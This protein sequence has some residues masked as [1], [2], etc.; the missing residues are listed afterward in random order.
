MTVI[1][2]NNNKRINICLKNEG[3]RLFLA[4]LLGEWGFMTTTTCPETEEDLL[5]ADGICSHCAGHVNRINLLSSPYIDSDHVNLPIVIEKLWQSVEKHYHRPPRHHLRLVVDYP[6]EMELR[7]SVQPGQL[8][9]LS[10]AGA[11][12]TLPRELAVGEI[13]PI[14]LLLPRQQQPLQL[15]GRVI[16]V[17]TFP[18]HQN[19]YDAGVLFE[20][21]ESQEKTLLRNSIVFSVFTQ[22]RAHLPSWAF[23]VG[24]NHFDLSQELRKEL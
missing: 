2:R 21:I 17:S 23:E 13:L 19:H 15:R 12:L 24:I 3:L 14:T 1:N 22:I 16:Y 18:D 5:L 4:E 8:N 9:S 10:P 11:R 6:I 20:G 7:G